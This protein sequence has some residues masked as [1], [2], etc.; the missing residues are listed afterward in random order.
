[1]PD[2]QKAEDTQ[3]P[4]VAIPLPRRRGCRACHPGLVASPCPRTARCIDREAKRVPQESICFVTF[5]SLASSLGSPVERGFR[6][7]RSGTAPLKQ[8]LCNPGVR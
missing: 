6:R 4:A 7:L 5:S 8:H 3:D 2:G 1:M